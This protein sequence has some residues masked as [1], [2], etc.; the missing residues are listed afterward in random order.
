MDYFDTSRLRTLADQL[1][2]YG[3]I[4]HDHGVPGLEAWW[5]NA[6]ESLRAMVEELKTLPA[7][8][9]LVTREP[10]DLAAIQALRPPG[11]RRLWAQ[12]DGTEYRD[13]LEGALYGRIAGNLLGAPVE[14]WSLV[15]MQDLARENG[16]P[17]P[18]VDYWKRVPRPYELHNSYS[19]REAYTRGKMHGVPVD[20]DLI[21]TL[22]G[23]L[24]LEASGPGFTTEDVARAW[25]QYLPFGYTAE[26]V[27]LRN[28]REGVSAEESGAKDNPFAEWI[29]AD[30]R[31]DPWGY[32]AP[33]WPERAAALAYRD[34]YVSHRRT[35]IYGEMMFSAAIAAAFSVRD[36][37]EAIAI[38]LT[39][40]PAECRL[41]NHV[42]WALEEAP[43]IRSYRQAR[44]AVDERFSG[45]SAAHTINNACLTIFGLAIGGTDHTRVISETVA[46][47]MDNDC[48]AATSGSIVGAI[49]GRVGISEHWTRYF[50]NRIATYMNGVPELALDDV[51]DR[52]AAQAERVYAAS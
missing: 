34:A 44:A 37:L 8:P 2:L 51:L 29:G 24:I 33:G 32:V 4:Q 47:G 23:L 12:L 11:P 38:G 9:A 39:E 49:V 45:M 19:L 7:D 6:E 28:L 36:P 42:R 3:Q 27:T 13:R 40:I 52:F 30:I 18:P 1:H 46:M 25:L 41:A 16:D 21:Y 14:G 50:D 5:A 43:H 26:E 20:D 17:F 35:G 22:L 48:T 31:S 10:N 15:A